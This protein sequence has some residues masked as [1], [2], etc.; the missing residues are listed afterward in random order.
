MTKMIDKIE[1]NMINESVHN[2]RIGE[3]GVKNIEIDEIRGFIIVD[4]GT[5]EIGM[6]KVLIPLQNV[7]KCEFIDKGDLIN[8]N[9]G[10]K[11]LKL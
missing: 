1:I 9:S 2:F 7:E 10:K 4:Y 11:V 3:F 5:M 8:E 6:K